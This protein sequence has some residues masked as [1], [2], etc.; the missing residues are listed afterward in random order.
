MPS[1]LVIN[2]NSSQSITQNLMHLLE[3][4]QDFTYKF[5]TGP[6]SSPSGILGDS[7]SVAPA[8]IDS[9]TT[10][11]TSAAACLPLI[12]PIIANH[13]AFLVAC[14]SDHPLVHMLREHTGTKPVLGIFHASVVHSLAQGRK[15]AIVTTAKVWE[16][17]LD[18]AVLAMLGSLYTYAGTY[19]TGMGVLELHQLPTE[20][21][22]ERLAQSAKKA[23]EQGGAKAIV[24]GCAGLSGLDAAIRQACGPDIVIIDSVIAGTEILVGLVR[25]SLANKED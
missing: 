22:N 16:K 25:A 11:I 12:L 3:P 18:D 23:V 5:F 8:Q 6:S 17:L 24:L 4:P 13:D 7:T 14:Y 19:S 15:F 1:I 21:V 9:Y 2:P 10:G 20:Q